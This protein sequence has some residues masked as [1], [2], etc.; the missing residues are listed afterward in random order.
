MPATRK[1]NVNRKQKK[2]KGRGK[3][4]KVMIVAAV[5]CHPSMIQKMR[6]GKRK[7]M[8][9]GMRGGAWPFSDSSATSVTPT[10]VSS[11]T[12]ATPTDFRCKL[13]SLLNFMKPA[14]CLQNTGAAPTLGSQQ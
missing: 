8:R 1:R 14:V 10:S 7:G 13:P 9:G 3:T 2:G 6:G 11:T 4:M 12:S 5:P